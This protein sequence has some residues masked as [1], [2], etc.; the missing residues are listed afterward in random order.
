MSSPEDAVLE[1]FEDDVALAQ[2]IVRLR[3]QRAE[4]ADRMKQAEE[5]LMSEADSYEYDAEGVAERNR[6]R[7]KAQGVSLCRDYLR[8]MT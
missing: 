8:G 5:T 6:L 4:L 7:Y 1:E 2:E 3:E